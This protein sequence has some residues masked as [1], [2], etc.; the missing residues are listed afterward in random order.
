MFTVSFTKLTFIFFYRRIF[1][2]GS[3]KHNVFG[4]V[5]VGVT[6]LIVLWIIGFVFAFIFNCGSDILANWTWKIEKEKCDHGLMA[7]NG[8]AISDFLTDVIVFLLPIPM[9][10]SVCPVC[11]YMLT[12]CQILRLHMTRG[13]KIAV[14]GIFGVGFV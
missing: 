11:F 10:R 13:R 12:T 8:L 1:V 5:T 2:T 3:S 7:E 9:V 4:K 14:L 6:V